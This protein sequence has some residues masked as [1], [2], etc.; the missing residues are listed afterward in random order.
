[1]PTRRLAPLSFVVSLAL[2]GALAPTR[3]AEKPAAS[4]SPHLI[5]TGEF[6]LLRARIGAAAVAR[7][8]YIYTIGGD[9]HGAITD[10]ERFDVRTHQSVRIYDQLLPRRYHSAVEHEGRIYLFGGQGY[11]LSGEAFED[12][13]EIFDC[14]KGTLTRGTSM[15]MPREN[16]ASAKIGQKVYLIGGSKLVENVGRRIVPANDTDIYDLVAGTW[17]KGAPLP[18]ARESS[19]GVV[20]GFIVVPGGFRANRSDDT[21]EVLDPQDNTWRGLPP[22]SRKI[23]AHSVAFLDRYLFLFGDYARLDS[24]LAYDLGKK[25]SLEVTTNFKGVRHTAAVVLQNTIY[26]IG[27]VSSDGTESDLIQAF[28][29]EPTA[30]TPSVR[31]PAGG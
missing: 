19:A 27:G 16:M 30:A 20:G 10:I 21:V 8:H 7:D 25:A 31:G 6:H 29:L 9:A 24:V 2:I 4:Q 14:A 26:I 23:S 28:A 18:T 15:P 3:A 1:M 13:V 12:R 17:A 22:L 11:L 5:K